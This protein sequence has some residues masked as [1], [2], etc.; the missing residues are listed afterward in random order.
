[1]RV[2]RFLFFFWL[3]MGVNLLV[4]PRLYPVLGEHPIMENNVPLA[5]FCFALAVY[6]MVR[7]RLI[8]AREIEREKE[9][10]HELRRRDT[11]KPID[12]TFDFSD[13]KPREGDE[14]K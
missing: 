6:N 11:G 13:P 3:L 7:W 12:P 9:L 8:R 4:L 2:Y 1:M 14:K 10:E 5:G